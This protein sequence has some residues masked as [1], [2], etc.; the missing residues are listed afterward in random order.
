MYPTKNKDCLLSAPGIEQI[1]V[2]EVIFM[3]MNYCFF[4]FF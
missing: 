2:D 4:L 1:R 3:G